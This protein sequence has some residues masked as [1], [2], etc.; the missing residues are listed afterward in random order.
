MKK[1]ILAIACFGLLISMLPAKAKKSTA[2]TDGVKI[3]ILNTKSEI[4]SKWDEIA[5]EYKKLT[6]VNVEVSITVGESPSQDITKRYA[7]GEVPTIY[8]GDIQDIIMLAEYAADLSHEKWATV[9]GT[10]Y[11]CIVNNKLIGFPFCIEARGLIYNATAI[12]KTTGKPFDPLKIKN[13]DDLKNL[14][15]ELVA[16]GMKT[17]VALNKE[18]WSLAG[19]FLSQVYEEQDGTAATTAKFINGLEKGTV[20]LENNKR[21]NSLMDTF[22]VLMQYNRSKSDPLS[23]DYDE[24]A[25][26]LAEGD[27]A[28][29]F[30]G[31]WAWPNMSDYVDKKSKYGIMPVVQPLSDN[32]ANEILCGGA[33]KFCMIDTKYNTAKQQQAAKDFL[34][35]LVFDTRGQSFLVRDC[36]LIPAFSNI[37]LKVSDPLGNSVQKYAAAG[38]LAQGFPNY[39]GDHWSALGAEM[40][41]YLAG[42]YTRNQ[43]AAVIDAYWQKKAE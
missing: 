17:P 16:D 12:E 33:T 29:W 35:W 18:D 23:A 5:K 8:M 26:A 2:S 22:S 34:N 15:S 27:V 19:H 1:T 9:G 38:M 41:K 7:S 14:L 21:W 11:G 6:G 24:N 31:N 36:G 37:T 13:L 10:K 25:V 40:Q 43:F 20:T 4:Q 3:T 30:N 42:G 39:P 28:F 32:K